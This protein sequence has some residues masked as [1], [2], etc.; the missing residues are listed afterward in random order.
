MFNTKH[1]ICLKLFIILIISFCFSIPAAAAS[2]PH[3]NFTVEQN[4]GDCQKMLKLLN[5]ERS[6]RG[7]SSVSIDKTLTQTALQPL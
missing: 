5:K 4:Y 3:I 6:K 2:L 1:N 7:L